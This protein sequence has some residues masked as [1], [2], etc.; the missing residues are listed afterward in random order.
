LTFYPLDYKVKSESG[1]TPKKALGGGGPVLQLYRLLILRRK[2]LKVAV[3]F[4]RQV[5]LIANPFME[6]YQKWALLGIVTFLSLMVINNLGMAAE[7]SSVKIVSP[8]EGE[9]V[10]GPKVKAVIKTENFKLCEECIGKAS[11]PGE[12]HAHFFLDGKLQVHGGD[13]FEFEGVKPG[14]H[15]LLVEIRN[16]DHSELG[17]KP[18]DPPYIDVVHFNVK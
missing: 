1:L 4:Q 9:T 16:N 12:G 5:L 8:K 14:P 3:S 17:R 2:R 7:Q 10:Q 13:S 11:K 18:T 15:T 6:R